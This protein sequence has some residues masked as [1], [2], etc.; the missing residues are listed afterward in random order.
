MFSMS[1]VNETSVQPTTQ[2]LIAYPRQTKMEVVVMTISYLLLMIAIIMSNAL[3]ITAFLLERTLRRNTNT[4]IMSLAS[5]DLLVGL[6]LVP[7]WV[8]IVVST[9]YSDGFY[10]FYITCDIFIS[11]AS[12]LQITAINIERCLA[13]LYPLKHRLTTRKMYYISLGVA[14]LYAA[15]IALLQPIQRQKWERVYIMVITLT[16]Y[17]FPLIIIFAAYG[18]IFT[19]AKNANRIVRNRATHRNS[20]RFSLTV[21]CITLLFFA[22]WLP[23]FGLSMAATYWPNSLPDHLTTSRLVHAAKWIHYCNSCI[24]PVLYSYGSPEIKK[25]I[26]NTICRLMGKKEQIRTARCSSTRARE[27]SFSHRQPSSSRLSLKSLSRKYSTES[28]PGKDKRKIS[29]TS[30]KCDNNNNPR[31]FVIASSV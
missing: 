1:S 21:A 28:E 7:C 3:V 2:G 24:N 13:I 15:G 30:E 26:H 18:K 29:S 14:W 17:C 31:P 27:F 23:L 8:N 20:R 5:A 25:G 9:H 12:I 22:T 10:H 16:C 19:A 6:L 4:L 11:C